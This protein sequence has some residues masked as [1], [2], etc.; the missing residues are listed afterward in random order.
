MAEEDLGIALPDF[1]PTALQRCQEPRSLHLLPGP[2]YWPLLE[3]SP[4][5][6]SSCGHAGPRLPGRPMREERGRR[7]EKRLHA[8]PPDRT[9]GVPM[10]GPS[11]WATWEFQTSLFQ[12]KGVT[13]S[14]SHTSAP[15]LS[16]KDRATTESPRKSTSLLVTL[17]LYPSVVTMTLYRHST[18]GRV[19]SN[20]ATASCDSVV[21]NGVNQ[22]Y[23]CHRCDPIQVNHDVSRNNLVVLLIVYEGW[24]ER[25]SDNPLYNRSNRESKTL[26]SGREVSM[27]RVNQLCAV[28][29]KGG[30]DDLLH[31]RS[32]RKPEIK[33][34]ARE[35]LMRRVTQFGT[36]ELEGRSEPGFR[37]SIGRDA[38]PSTAPPR[39]KEDRR[40][41]APLRSTD[42]PLAP[43][44][45][46]RCTPGLWP[47][48]PDGTT[49]L[50]KSAESL[51]G[52]FWNYHLV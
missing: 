18:G 34:S 25:F 42:A 28:E 7:K 41:P 29:L 39:S 23:H 30:S 31:N 33:W 4:P 19:K 21:N 46:V 14:K 49:I 12:G 45:G 37:P 32:N 36:A 2:T 8:G 44:D 3:V 47:A 6:W 22:M 27:R 20:I 13:C 43:P 48:I 51:H 35:T 26:W 17:V 1:A 52:R 50:R 9:C 38:L 16:V 11:T 15:R 24:G 40:R 5:G 10:P